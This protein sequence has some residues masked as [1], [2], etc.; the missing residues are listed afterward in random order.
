MLPTRPRPPL[1]KPI[2]AAANSSSARSWATTTNSHFPIRKPRQYP[3]FLG[4][5]RAVRS[6]TG[7]GCHEGQPSFTL[8][9]IGSRWFRRHISRPATITRPAGSTRRCTWGR[10]RA[11]RDRWPIAWR[12]KGTCRTPRSVD[13][14]RIRAGAG[15]CVPCFGLVICSSTLG[16]RCTMELAALADR[17][18]RAPKG[19]SSSRRSS[20]GIPSKSSKGIGTGCLKED[21]WD[22]FRLLVPRTKIR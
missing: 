6:Q 12:G 13:R 16:S 1:E 21:S 3:V 14:E 19:T 5:V 10:S 8:V 20:P 17:R 9:F 18:V 4:S 15:D 2:P 11:G 22:H 7:R